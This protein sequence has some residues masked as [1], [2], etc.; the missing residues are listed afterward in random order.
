MNSAVHHPRPT[1]KY[2]SM[3]QV[4]YDWGLRIEFFRK[5]STTTV[6]NQ[7]CIQSCLKGF[8]INMQAFSVAYKTL[9]DFNPATDPDARV[10]LSNAIMRFFLTDM[11]TCIEQSIRSMWRR[12]EGSEGAFKYSILLKHFSNKIGLC[13]SSPI[14]QAFD[15][16]VK[17]RNTMHNGFVP[18]WNYS[19]R[20]GNMKFSIKKGK[21]VKIPIES[22][23]L[24]IDSFGTIWEYSES[25]D[26]AYLKTVW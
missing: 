13:E 10:N 1:E 2:K 6:R 20:I 7:E 12:K 5:F 3:G 9:M 15:A 24:F 21:E 17:L 16:L 22:V 19:G 25:I 26:E 18:N 14:Y 4:P 8:A 23:D 11:H